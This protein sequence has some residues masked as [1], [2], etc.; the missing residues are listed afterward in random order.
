MP[1]SLPPDFQDLIRRM[2]C[3]DTKNR[4]TISNIKNHPAFL[5]GYPVGYSLP[6]PVPLVFTEEPIEPDEEIVRFLE[7]IGFESTKEVREELTCPGY[8]MAKVFYQLL[9]RTTTPECLPWASGHVS[10]SA[11]P[12]LYQMTT[13]E[14]EH[15]EVMFPEPNLR[16]CDSS[17][18][19]TGSMPDPDGWAPFPAGFVMSEESWFKLKRNPIALL[20][21]QLQ[22]LLIAGGY[23]FFHPNPLELVAKRGADGSFAYVTVIQEEGWLDLR[24]QQNGQTASIRELATAVGTL[25]SNWAGMEDLY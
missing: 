20:M 19:S 23:E 21:F 7:H 3:V 13:E 11:P 1:A 14:K 9:S 2:L 12:D 24:L 18:S 5:N 25:A 10:P 8:S 17:G 15:E 22:E 4:I 16:T 6:A